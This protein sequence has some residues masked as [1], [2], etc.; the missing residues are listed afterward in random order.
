MGT[1]TTGYNFLLYVDSVNN[2]ITPVYLKVAG[3][4]GAT[5]TRSQDTVDVTD[6]DSQRHMEFV[7]SLDSWTMDADGL[8]ELD[9]NGFNAV[10]T[11]WEQKQT[12]M[13]R[14][15]QVDGTKKEGLGIIT[16]LSIEAPYDGE[17][18]M[19]ISIQ[20]TGPLASV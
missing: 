15:E 14:L 16:E 12:I 10:E 13:V 7:T 11:A 17:A 8:L 4:R 2:P 6:K 9:D 18:S 20:G 3:Q 5:L 1:A 19:K